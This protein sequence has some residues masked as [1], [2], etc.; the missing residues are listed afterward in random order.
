MKRQAFVE[1][2]DDGVDEILATLASPPRPVSTPQRGSVPA[3]RPAQ[4]EGGSASSKTPNLKRHWKRVGFYTKDATWSSLKE[5][6]LERSL[7]GE[8]HDFSS[9]LLEALQKAYPD[10]DWEF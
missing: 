2:K 10:K 7:K 5:L 4:A 6:S 9:I 8:P 3:P 1:P